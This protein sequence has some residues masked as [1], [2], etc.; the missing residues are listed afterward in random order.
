MSN[1]IG[2]LTE[3][4]YREGIDKANAD[5]EKILNEAR[6]KAKEI[7]KNAEKREQE[8]I[9]SAEKKA[10]EIKS[11]FESEIKLSA[12]QFIS[13]LKQEINNMITLRQTKDP[14]AKSMNDSDFIKTV[15][16]ELIKNWKSNN[17][18][19]LNLDIALSE[20]Y[21][22]SLKSYSEKIIKE[23]FDSSLEI[24]F[25]EKIRTGFKIAPKEGNYIISFT[26]KD[27]ENL[28]GHY[29][30]GKNSQLIFE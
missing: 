16:I 7:L 22:E 9:G 30:R 19:L 21:K 11:N 2:E 24:V 26:D 15:I 3:K 14:V 5:A 27:F 4:I 29:L 20:K 12:K 13:N 23:N 17:P 25:D 18:E 8:I 1:K 28:F 10:E 6:N